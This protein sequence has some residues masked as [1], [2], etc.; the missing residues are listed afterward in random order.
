MADNHDTTTSNDVWSILIDTDSVLSN[1]GDVIL[2]LCS[3]S[4]L[5]QPIQT[6]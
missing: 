4:Q 3:A 2:I 6:N 5:Y 1:L